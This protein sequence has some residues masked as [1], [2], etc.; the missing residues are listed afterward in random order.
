MLRCLMDR[1]YSGIVLSIRPLTVT[2]ADKY[3]GLL[4]CGIVLVFC[5]P[6]IWSIIVSSS[7]RVQQSHNDPSEHQELLTQLQNIISQNACI[8]K[9]TTVRY[10]IWQSYN[11]HQHNNLITHSIQV[12]D[13]CV[14]HIPGH[15][16]FWSVYLK[17][18]S[19]VKIIQ[20][21]GQLN[22]HVALV[23]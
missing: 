15:K 4:G 18:L 1:R 22:E 3:L 23:E 5:L 14:V 21:Q 19:T 10:Q 20:H 8:P 7:S 13:L 2:L 16:F 17:M 11:T 9:H 6:T 12:S